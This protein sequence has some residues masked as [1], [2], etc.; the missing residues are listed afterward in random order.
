M[1]PVPLTSPITSQ[2]R[3][4]AERCTAC[5]GVPTMFLAMLQDLDERPRDL[6]SLR[7]GIMAGALCPVE[8]M[9]RV[10]SKMHMTEVTICYG[11]TET[12]PLSFQSFTDDPLDKR[13]ETVG[14]IHP[15]LEVK[16]IGEDGEVVPVGQRGE[17][18]T[19]GYSVMKGYWDD[20]EKTAESIRDGWMITGDLA[21]LDDKGFC[22]IVGRVKDMIIRGGE[23]V[24]P[25][26]VEEFLMS[27]P[28]VA[29]VQVF[30]IPDEKYGEAVCAWVIPVEAMI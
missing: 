24:Y 2:S 19:R 13:C 10:Q 9:R 23:N 22:T 3:L 27:H 12:S 30:G 20:P 4:S 25:R 16:I 6:T 1:V 28:E 18:C 21:Q 5:Y 14:R 8:I 29:D 17:L 11:M 15:H 7:T 26:E